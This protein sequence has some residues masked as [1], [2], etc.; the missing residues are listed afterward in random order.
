LNGEPGSQVSRRARTSPAVARPQTTQNASTRTGARAPGSVGLDHWTITTWQ[1]GRR[2]TPAPR[3]NRRLDGVAEEG[4]EQQAPQPSRHQVGLEP[5]QSQLRGQGDA[6]LGQDPGCPQEPP[7]QR[8]DGPCQGTGKEEEGHAPGQLPHR[9][10]P[11]PDLDFEAPPSHAPS[12]PRIPP[13]R[14][15]APRIQ[16]GAHGPEAAGQG[17]PTSQVRRAGARLRTMAASIT[18]LQARPRKT[19][20]GIPQAAPSATR[21]RMFP[22]SRGACSGPTPALPRSEASTRTAEEARA[23]VEKARARRCRKARMEPLNSLQASWLLHAGWPAR[24]GGGVRCGM[25]GWLQNPTWRARLPAKE[26]WTSGF[27]EPDGKGPG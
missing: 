15:Q 10:F 18:W 7:S 26:I 21:G 11:R 14:A 4:K 2:P 1:A 23:P 5:L 13:Q 8:G 12:N 27:R 9:R 19:A 16:A 20:K 24:D 17:P 25:E 22:A 6:P 3:P